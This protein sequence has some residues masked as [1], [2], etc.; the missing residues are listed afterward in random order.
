[1]DL[2]FPAFLYE[3]YTANL[4]NLEEGLFKGKILVQ[5]SCTELHGH[6]LTVPRAIKLSSRLP[7][8]QK[9]LRVMVMVLTSL[10]I[11][12]VLKQPW[13]SRSRNMSRKLLRWRKS[14]PAQLHISPVK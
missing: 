5:V 7:P 9:T 8:Q 4:D 13:E 6:D 10:R 3:K 2:S 1:M 14:L 12:D 11:T